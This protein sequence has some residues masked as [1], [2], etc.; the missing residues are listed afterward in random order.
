LAALK[1]K[2][3]SANPSPRKIEQIVDILKNDGVIAYPTDSVYALGCNPY[4]KKGVTK[5]CKL[6]G[7]DPL[8]SNLT[9][10]CENI[11]EAALLGKH[12][13]NRIFKIMK[14]Y[15]PGPFTFI[16]QASKEI[17][18]YYKNKRK[19]IGI[20][21]PDH[22]IVQAI[23]RQFAYP[24][25]STSLVKD[26]DSNIYYDEPDDIFDDLG[27]ILDCIIDGGN[28][29]QQPTAII[30]CTHTQIE[31]KREGPIQFFEL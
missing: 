3:F 31:L 9:M 2:L 16:L 27:Y 5:M 14:A 24:L 29:G 12:L 26:R 18:S 7:L 1:L 22:T 6:K 8:K 17:P 4:S 13:D 15:T 25:L 20:R 19:T 30:D 28:V 23:L 11:S 21:I 10:L